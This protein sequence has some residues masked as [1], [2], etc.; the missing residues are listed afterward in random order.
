MKIDEN[1]ARENKNGFLRAPAKAVMVALQLLAVGSL[2]FC[3][4]VFALFMGNGGDLS[5]LK[6]HEKYTSTS[7]CGDAVWSNLEHI[8]FRIQTAQFLN[9]EGVFDPEQKVDINRLAE[10]LNQGDKSAADEIKA[11]DGRSYTTQQLQDMSRKGVADQ[12][13]DMARYGYQNSDRR[14][15]GVN[16][17]YYSC[18]SKEYL[19]DPEAAFTADEI[20]SLFSLSELEENDQ[21]REALLENLD[22]RLVNGYN[23]QDTDEEI[24]EQAASGRSGL[25]VLTKEEIDTAREIQK[26]SGRDITEFSDV[27]IY[28]YTEGKKLEEELAK[29]EA[30]AT[31]AEYAAQ[32]SKTIS[33]QDMYNNLA[34]V[35]NY[36]Q[37]Y[38]SLDDTMNTKYSN[39]RFFIQDSA[40]HVYTN[41]EE[42]KSKKDAVS[43]DMEELTTL[44]STLYYK[45]ENGNITELVSGNADTEAGKTLESRTDTTYGDGLLEGT[46]IV[47]A[48]VDPELKAE[49]YISNAAERYERF[50]PMVI[51]AIIVGI[52]SGLI[53]LAAF[54]LSNL[55]SGHRGDKRVQLYMIDRIPTEVSAGITITV[56]SLVAAFDAW[57]ASMMLSITSIWFVVLIAGLAVLT[58]SAFL[59]FYYGLVRRIKGK[60]L[61]KASLVRSIVSVC[62]NVY[63]A[64]KTSSKLILAFGGFVLLHM[65]LI[66]AFSGFGVFM[67]L[68]LDAIV[69]LYLLREAAGRQT[70]IEGLR[71]IGAGELDYKVD[72]INLG[73]DNLVL[74][75]TLNGVGDGLNA[76]IQERM[77]SERLKADLITNVS[78]DIKTP[79]TSIIN[80]VDLLQRENIQDEKIKGYL[81]VLANKSQRLKQLT[82]DLV[83]ASKVSSGNV[84]LEFAVLNLNELVLQ[85]NGEFEEKFRSRNLEVICTLSP[86][87]LRISADGRR[88]W[89]VLENLYGNVYKYGMPG[90]RVYVNTEKKD[91]IIYFSIKNISEN[92]LNI[93]ADE[94]TERFIRGDVSRSTEGSGLGL[95]IAKNLT[96]LQHGEF[97]IYLDGDLFKVVISF[98]EVLKGNEGNTFTEYVKDEQ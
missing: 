46:E 22:Q 49:D 34:V 69:L 82:E 27:F 7:Q 31:L 62:K 98:H 26:L 85:I 64:R 57:I 87:T 81:E 16:D 15:Y 17:L 75:E 73:G 44:T 93:N 94:L 23:D 4:V 74:A 65:F 11:E 42:W 25:Q 86:D 58:W 30:G 8:S 77:K 60:N 79:L 24:S 68:I 5:N 66:I 91:G 88:I 36:M 37:E 41:V 76:A 19:A 84:K 95:S 32:N 51:P 48:G 83:E 56:M 97:S 13:A 14:Y 18:F 6:N 59:F 10:K 45:R 1:K 3:M 71:R 47:F 80:Y 72:V 9:E 29:T 96:K 53:L 63:A 21:E 89:R 39:V 52:L 54:V 70:V 40:G 20:N 61:W 33:L 55:Q 28:L 12:F 50:S 35:L 2:T 38:E 90:T 43:A 92:S 67:C 78:H